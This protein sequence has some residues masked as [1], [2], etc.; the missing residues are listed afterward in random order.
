[1]NIRFDLFSSYFPSFKINALPSLTPLQRR[2]TV[3]ALIA[4]ACLAALYLAC[5]FLK[6]TI[7]SFKNNCAKLNSIGEMEQQVECVKQV[8]LLA[9]MNSWKTTLGRNE[10][11]QTL[12]AFKIDP[13]SELNAERKHLR[14]VILGSISS[15]DRRIL[16]IVTDYLKAAHRLETTL[17]ATP[18]DLYNEHLRHR[19][20][21]Q[22]PIETHLAKLRLQAEDN[23]FL[24]GFTS[25]DLYS[26]FRAGDINFVFGV[27]DVKSAC[28]LFS[29]HR[30]STQN[31]EQTLKRVMKVATHE[32]AHM[33]GMPHC[34]RYLCNMQGTNNLEDADKVPL[35]F[36]GQDMAKICYLNHWTLKEGYENQLHFFENFFHCYGEIID[37]SLEI[38]DLKKKLTK[39]AYK[40]EHHLADMQTCV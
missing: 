23:T 40:S 33:R 6:K 4:F 1:M 13:N 25:E 27:G 34:T 30:F 20:H 24:L 32:F 28:G 22:Y 2:V 12:E 26:Y 7:D 36:C 8:D 10:E 29:L 19:G 31:F 18:L 9:E 5:C 11:E 3:V 21:P 35:I 15:R 38:D 17:D 14:I 39:L 16:E 37:F